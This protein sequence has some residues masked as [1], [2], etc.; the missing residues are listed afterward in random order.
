MNDHI[1]LVDE[2]GQPYIAHAGFG[3]G[4]RQN[5]KYLMK[6]GEGAKARYLYTQAEVQA[7]MRGG[8]KALK[9][10]ANKASDAVGI[11]AKKKL[12]TAEGKLQFATDSV[13]NTGTMQRKRSGKELNAAQQKAA[14]DFA[15]ASRRY[16]E[17][18]ATYE[19]SALGKAEKAASSLKSTKDRMKE[20]FRNKKEQVTNKVDEVREDALQK[21]V[22]KAKAEQ[23]KINAQ[24]QAEKEIEN[25]KNFDLKKHHEGLDRYERAAETAHKIDSFVNNED[26]P[27][28]PKEAARVSQLTVKMWRATQ[29]YGNDKISLE[30]RDKILNEAEKEINNLAAKYNSGKKKLK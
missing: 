16:G 14:D 10:A 28:D 21:K 29:D 6:I 24:K 12:K 8:R 26:N 20:E 30:E 22:E 11:S 9:N 5:H 4:I 23:R 3:R 25:R 2:T 15:S 17:A 18:K 1:I 7:Y 19:K 13:L 27:L